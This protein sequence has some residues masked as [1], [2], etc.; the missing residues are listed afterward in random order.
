MSDYHALLL[1]GTLALLFGAI[2]YVRG[3]VDGRSNVVAMLL[4][5]GGGAA[6]FGA[7]DAGPNGASAADLVPA[8]EQLF[9]AI[10]RLIF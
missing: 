5:L 7:E 6:L 10:G 8:V 4:T 2:W 9:T 1:F 3:L